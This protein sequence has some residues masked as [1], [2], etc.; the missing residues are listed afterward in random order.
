MV[1]KKNKNKPIAIIVP[2]IDNETKKRKRNKKKNKKTKV[3]NFSNTVPIKN[4][5]NITT[6]NLSPLNEI[7][8]EEKSKK[9][10]KF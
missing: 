9:V 6:A 1:S 10:N 4:E 5:I 7:K 2:K 8:L 3:M